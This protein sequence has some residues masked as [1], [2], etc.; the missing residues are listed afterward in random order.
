M[1]NRFVAENKPG[2]TM[3]R[4]ANYSTWWNGGLRTTVY[5]HNMIGLLTET[6]GNPTP[7]RSGVRAR[8]ADHERRPAL[9]DQAADLALP[10]VDRVLDHRE[11]G[12][13]RRRVTQ[14]GALPLQHLQDGQGLDRQRLARHLDD[15]S[16]ADSGGEGRHRAA[17]DAATPAAPG[18]R[19]TAAAAAARSRSISTTS[20]MQR[21]EWRDARAYVLPSDQTDFLT[22]TKFVNA[23]IKTGIQIHRATAPF[24]VGGKTVSRGF[25]RREDGAGVPPARARHVRAAGSSERL[26]VSRRPADSALRQR[27]LDARLSD[28][29]EVRSRARERRRAARAGRHDLHQAARR[30]A[31][32][33]RPAPSA[34]SSATA[35]TTRSS[36]STAC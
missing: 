13:A 8:S 20:S 18:G 4:G 35:S 22:A 24:S 11:P 7:M 30:D 29:R 16:E 9:P 19:R 28:G 3:R 33:K 6:I 26:P 14:Q 15:V 31:S 27:R 10:P 23:L 36:P 12:G 2:A 32:S 5:F 34:T 21:P 17:R 25:V 1:H